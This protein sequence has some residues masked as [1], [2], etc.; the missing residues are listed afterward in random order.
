[1]SLSTSRRSRNH[2]SAEL[3]LIEHG[4]CIEPGGPRGQGRSVA[5]RSS[6]SAKGSDEELQFAIGPTATSRPALAFAVP[7]GSGYRRSWREQLLAPLSPRG[8][9]GSAA[10]RIRAPRAV[11]AEAER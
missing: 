5:S 8:R 9:R 4:F 1:V 7:A 3:Y 11:Y 2:L 10:D 6:S